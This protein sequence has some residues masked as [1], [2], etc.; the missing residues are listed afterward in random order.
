MNDKQFAELKE[1]IDQQLKSGIEV[2]VNGKIRSLSEKI[3]TY[4]KQDE[5]WKEGVTP[6][7]EM[8]KHISNFSDTTIWILKTFLLVASACGA[9]YAFFRFIRN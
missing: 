2:N 9:F 1:S 8:M 3:D 5:E 6:S 7:I 4:I